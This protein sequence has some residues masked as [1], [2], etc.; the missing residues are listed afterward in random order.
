MLYLISTRTVLATPVIRAAL[1]TLR[2]PPV[3][4]MKPSQDG[5][6]HDFAIGVGSCVRAVWIGEAVGS[7]IRGLIG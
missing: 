2:R 5:P 7:E 3:I 6:H 4:V 1:S